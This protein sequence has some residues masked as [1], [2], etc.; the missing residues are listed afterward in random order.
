MRFEVV[1]SVF[2][3]RENVEAVAVDLYISSD[4]NI[5]RSNELVILI[6]VL[7]LAALEEFAFDNARVLLSRF[8][9]GD[10]VIRQ[11]ERND[12]AALDI[13]RDTSVEASCETEDLALIINS[14]EEV[15]LGLL[16]N[17]AVN[18]SE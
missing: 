14:L 13:L 7:V 11:E 12:E 10:R 4:S 16:G 1:L 2:I 17:E 6:N 8:I 5:G 18:I 9:D 3:A 15:L